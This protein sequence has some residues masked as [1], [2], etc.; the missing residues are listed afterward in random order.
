MAAI[1]LNDHFRF[2]TALETQHDE[3]PGQPATQ[4][5][6]VKVAAYAGVKQ[7]HNF[8]VDVVV[9][10][11]ITAAPEPCRPAPTVSVVGLVTSDY[12][13]Y[14][15][16]DHIADKLCATFERYGTAQ[17]P[18]SR[19]RDLVDLVVIARTQTVPAQALQN[20]IET[21]RLHRRL[22]PIV[23]YATPELWSSQ[24]AKAA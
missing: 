16:V 9:G 22:D 17:H 1:D 4:L 13:L 21:E 19:V 11:I 3:R 5:A 14:P 8:T 6:T 24:Y 2:V 20:A 7:V 12:L 10:S 18:S 23:R 15:M